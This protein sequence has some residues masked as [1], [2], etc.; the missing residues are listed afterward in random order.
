VLGNLSDLWGRWRERRR[1]YQ[2]E[3][4][5]HKLNGGA[6]GPFST[7]ENLERIEMATGSELPR[8]EAPKGKAPDL[9][10]N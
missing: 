3:R 10:A 8:V 4:A 5:L 9:R 2:L 6:T 1:Q 7:M